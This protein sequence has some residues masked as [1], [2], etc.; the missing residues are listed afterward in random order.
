MTSIDSPTADDVTRMPWQQVIADAKHCGCFEYCNAF[1]RSAA[2]AEAEGD[3][4]AQNVYAFF[5]RVT[6]LHFNLDEPSA[7]LGPEDRLLGFTDAELALLAGIVV[8]IADPEMRAR[9]ADI[10]IGI[11]AMT[12]CICPRG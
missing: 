8:D 9:V 2:E 7:P 6:S 10:V 1:C 12:R 11:T 5:A 3:D 4:R